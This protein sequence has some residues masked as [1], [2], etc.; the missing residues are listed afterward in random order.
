MCVLAPSYLRYGVYTKSD[1]FPLLLRPLNKFWV[2]TPINTFAVLLQSFP[3]KEDCYT[4]L[5]SHIFENGTEGAT[6]PCTKLAKRYAFVEHVPLHVSV[7][8]KKGSQTDL[9]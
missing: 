7:Q 1:A 3:G 5:Y 8:S 9:D 4:Q 6:V 2:P